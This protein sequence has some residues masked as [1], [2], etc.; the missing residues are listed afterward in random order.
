[1]WVYK[2]V[3]V[4]WSGEGKTTL[5]TLYKDCFIVDDKDYFRLKDV[6]IF[7]SDRNIMRQKY[8]I[9]SDQFQIRQKYNEHV[10]YVIILI[11]AFLKTQLMFNV[12]TCLSRVSG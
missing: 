2:F 3:S 6:N 11:S 4:G 9:R 8:Q 7:Q 1:M 10:H 5:R 12:C